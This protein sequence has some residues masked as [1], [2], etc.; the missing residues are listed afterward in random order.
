MSVLVIEVSKT[1]TLMWQ[2]D[3]G[4]FSDL[5]ADSAG[6]V[7]ARKLDGC[8]SDRVPADNIGEVAPA[9]HIGAALLWA[10]GTC[11]IFPTEFQELPSLTLVD[12]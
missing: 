9:P 11:I 12:P 3:R 6:S 2:G 7:P 10:S 1:V 5:C 4:G 8:P